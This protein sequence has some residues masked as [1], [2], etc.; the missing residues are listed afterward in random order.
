M[1]EYGATH[2]VNLLGSKENEAILTSAYAKHLQ[3]A[4][5]IWGDELSLTHY[6]FHNAVRI[7]GHDSVMRDLWYAVFPCENISSYMMASVV[8]KASIAIW[9]VTGSLCTTLVPMI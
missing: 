1:E 2:A 5:G 8:W 3:L 9:N 4:R 7:G 6:D